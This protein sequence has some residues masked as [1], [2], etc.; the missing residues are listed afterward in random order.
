MNPEIIAILK[1][2]AGA[3]GSPGDAPP[4]AN[5]YSNPYGYSPLTDRSLAPLMQQSQTTAM[6]AAFAPLILQ[7]VA[8]QLASRL[9]STSNIN[10]GLSANAQ[11]LSALQQ[12]FT[13][14]Q[15]V[16]QTALIGKVGQGL[17]M[18]KDATENLSQMLPIISMFA[19]E[20]GN[21]LSRFDPSGAGFGM[22]GAMM[23]AVKAGG[24][25]ARRVN[26]SSAESMARLYAQSKQRAGKE[27]TLAEGMQ[28]LDTSKTAGLSI[29]EMMQMRAG[30]VSRGIVDDVFSGINDVETLRGAMSDDN[31]KK[32]EGAKSLTDI[33]DKIGSVELEATRG[34]VMQ[35]TMKGS[36]E[37][38][39]KF[40]QSVR[41]MGSVFTSMQ[42]DTEGLLRMI[43]KLDGPLSKL[44]PEKLSKSMAKFINVLDKSGMTAEELAKGMEVFAARTGNTDKNFAMH[45][46]GRAGAA[47]AGLMRAGVGD[48]AAMGLA[49]E[50]ADMLGVEASQQIA[51]AMG[52]MMTDEGKTRLKEAMA[53]L[54]DPSAS[55]EAVDAARRFML[56]PRN[57]KGVIKAGKESLADS[58][59]LRSKTGDISADALAAAEARTAKEMGMAPE[60]WA[61]ARVTAAAGGMEA[62]LARSIEGVI[63]ADEAGFEEAQRQL[64]IELGRDVSEEDVRSHIQDSIIAQAKGSDKNTALALARRRG[65]VGK[66][67]QQYAESIMNFSSATSKQR[68]ALGAVS[69]DTI[70]RTRAGSVSLIEPDARDGRSDQEI[71]ADLLKS[72]GNAGVQ[73]AKTAVTAILESSKTAGGIDGG[74]AVIA[75]FKGLNIVGPDQELTAEQA[76]KI[77]SS[78]W[79]RDYAAALKEK[80]VTV[81]QSKLFAITADMATASGYGSPTQAEEFL[82]NPDAFV[83]ATAERGGSS[84]VT[85]EQSASESARGGGG[86]TEVKSSLDVTIT[87]AGDLKD[88]LTI[89][90][91]KEKTVVTNASLRDITKPSESKK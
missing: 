22:D 79:A 42:G 45:A 63:K 41:M 70:R 61:Q 19:P 37:I 21:M 81:R 32:T 1:A 2:L 20:V 46:V 23:S 47:R 55:P 71:E 50:A 53:I 9:Q 39:K 3:A 7:G 25:S 85:G 78:S 4:G 16:Q 15:N 40:A 44:D 10:P 74:E 8:P 88:N 75:A 30:L 84:T 60:E 11:H 80:D 48:E 83:K 36:E 27:G 62:D 24:L 64:G 31:R 13:K 52:D 58:M 54:K 14:V 56:D 73:D 59:V 67:A 68:T 29:S 51:G 43:E 33:R 72:A 65:Y 5:P 28:L 90:K 35:N 38:E 77:K 34:N 49:S 12:A 69:D 87:A 91:G 26:A 17:G 76:D 89:A 6:M 82:K 57:E 86:V 18:S 66:E